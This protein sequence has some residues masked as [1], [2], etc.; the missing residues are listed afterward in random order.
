MKLLLFVKSVG[1]STS[2]ETGYLQIDC[3]A[4]AVQL[5]IAAV[6]SVL[7]PNNTL[8]KESYDQHWQSCIMNV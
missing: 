4:K 6:T 8:I 7:Q 5:L 3:P 1:E 2:H